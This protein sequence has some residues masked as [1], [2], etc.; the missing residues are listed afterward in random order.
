MKLPAAHAAHSPRKRP[1][2]QGAPAL[3]ELQGILAK[4]NRERK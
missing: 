4:A 3:R 2:Q 1:A